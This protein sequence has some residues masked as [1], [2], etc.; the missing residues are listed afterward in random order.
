MKKIISVRSHARRTRS[1]FTPVRPHLRSIAERK[2]QKAL[3]KYGEFELYNM[4]AEDP[5]TAIKGTNQINWDYVY[6]Y[7]RKFY[8]QNPTAPV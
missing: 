3:D 6:E 4:I 2:F 8:K 5:K 1:G 7:W